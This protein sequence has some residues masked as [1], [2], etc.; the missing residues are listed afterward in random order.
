MQVYT[1][2]GKGKSTAAFGLALRAAGAGLKIFIGQFLKAGNCSE[3]KAFERFGEQVTVRCYGDLGFVPNPQSESDRLHARQ[4]FE[5]VREVVQAGEHD[6][7]VLD[8]INNVVHGGLIHEQE[9]LDLIR[10]K[11]EWV[12]LVLTGR[13]ATTAVMDASDLVTEMREIKHYYND[14]IPARLGIES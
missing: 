5:E 14:G 1:G 8:E 13:N 12:E 9:V 7:V 3:D 10:S 2:N 4:G 11:P 6:L